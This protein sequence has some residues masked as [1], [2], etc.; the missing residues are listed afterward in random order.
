MRGEEKH[1]WEGK[2]K[3]NQRAEVNYFLYIANIKAKLLFMHSSQL[4]EE[5]RKIFQ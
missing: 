1:V 3:L 2:I 5:Q 4:S